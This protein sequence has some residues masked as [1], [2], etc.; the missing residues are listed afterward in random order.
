MAATFHGMTRG[1]I[2]SFERSGRRAALALGAI[3]SVGGCS[4]DSPT[5]PPASLQIV[6]F[7]GGEYADPDGYTVTLSGDAPRQ[8]ATDA[9]LL[10][11]PIDPGTYTMTIS[12]IAAN[13]A[14]RGNASRNIEVLASE[15]ISARIEIDC[16]KQAEECFVDFDLTAS[17]GLTPEFTWNP[18]CRIVN[19][20]VVDLDWAG[21]GDIRWSMRREAPFLGPVQYGVAPTGATVTFPPQPLTAGHRILLAVQFFVNGVLESRMLLLTP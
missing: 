2:R 10:L 14:L 21:D 12:G 6:V 11:S 19:L 13:C 1:P 5:A 8:L 9:T 18:I 20:S 17:G 15:I 16:L 3:L 7:T 4:G